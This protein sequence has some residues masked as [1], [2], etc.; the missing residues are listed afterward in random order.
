[1]VSA[2]AITVS[3]GVTADN[4]RYAKTVESGT[5]RGR[6][7]ELSESHH[8]VYTPNRDNIGESLKYFAKTWLDY[9][10]L[11]VRSPIVKP[12]TGGLVVGSVT[13]SESPLLYVFPFC[14][15]A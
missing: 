10:R 9:G 15:L 5:C 7:S 4:G 11:P 14:I 3:N 13:T 12:L 2:F 8:H 1:M 6:F